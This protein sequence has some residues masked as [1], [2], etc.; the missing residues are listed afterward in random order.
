MNSN[1][2][3][4]CNH[5]NLSYKCTHNK[6]TFRAGLGAA[7]R[8]LANWS[9]IGLGRP[10]QP[11]ISTERED[12]TSR[13]THVRAMLTWAVTSTCQGHRLTH[14]TGTASPAAQMERDIQ[15]LSRHFTWLQHP[16]AF[17][18]KAKKTPEH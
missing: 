2:K 3:Y 4:T 16:K 9:G 15:L 17:T 18:F 6:N 1:K 13:V 7:N 8:G 10:R 12:I 11:Q 14:S 5:K